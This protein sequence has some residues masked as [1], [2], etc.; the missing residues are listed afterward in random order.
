AARA[1]ARLGCRRGGAARWAGAARLREQRGDDRGVRHEVPALRCM[2]THVVSP[3]TARRLAA[4]VQHG[5]HSSLARKWGDYTPD[6]TRARAVPETGVATGR[7]RCA[8]APRR[9]AWSWG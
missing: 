8:G 7:G 1:A 2:R 4:P 9:L 5:S 3:M 6:S